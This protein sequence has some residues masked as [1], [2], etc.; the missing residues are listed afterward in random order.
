MRNVYPVFF[1]KTNNC[2][3]VEVPDFGI[4]T[5]GKDMNDAIDMARD[6]I[7]LKCISMEDSNDEIPSPSELCLLNVTNGT[8]ADDGETIVSFV[9]IDSTEYRKNTGKKSGTVIQSGAKGYVVDSYKVY[10]QNGV[11][12]KR[13][14]LSRDT[15]SAQARIIAK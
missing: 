5:E 9:D 8:F 1:T 13:E 11:E 10:R 15:Y 6:A 12:V 3:F 14:K 7:E 4:L 2:I